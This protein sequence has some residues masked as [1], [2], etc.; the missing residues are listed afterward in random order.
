MPFIMGQIVPD[1]VERY[2]SGLNHAHDAVLDEI[3]RTGDT[4]GLPL[5]D[6]EV[7]AL[8]RVL[9]TADRC[10]GA[11]WKSARAS[12]TRASGWPARCRADGMLITM[13][14]DAGTRC[15]SRRPTSNARGSATA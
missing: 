4:Q 11:S 2:L 7:G 12:A 14:K 10:D 9:A 5:V 1:P 8:L 3:A 13:E 6:A 15:A